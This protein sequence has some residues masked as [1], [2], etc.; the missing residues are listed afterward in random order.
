MKKIS[1]FTLS[2]VMITVGIIGVIAALTVPNLVKNYQ[3]Q[4]QTVQ[5]NVSAS[6]CKN[7]IIQKS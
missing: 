1:A 5:L 4:A 7:V 3:R 2:E 6:A